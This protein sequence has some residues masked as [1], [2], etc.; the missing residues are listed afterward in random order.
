MTAY[1]IAPGPDP[2][3]QARTRAGL[4]AGFGAYGLWGLLPLY[5]VLLDPA[6]PTEIVA[7]RVLFSLVFCL[8]LLAVTR[9]LGPLGRALRAPRTLGA[10]TLAGALIGVNWFLYT[11]ATTTGNTL[12]ASL[13]YFINPLVAV[14]L[15]VVVLHERMRPLQWAAIAVGFTAVV[16]M[17]V[18]YGQVPWLALGLAFSFG[19]Y[20]LVKNLVGGSYPAIVTLTVETMALAPVA[21]WAVGALAADGRLTL[22]TEG[23]SHLLLL[24]ASGV[25]TAVPLILFGVAASR[26]P[27]STVGMIQYLAPIMQFLIAV[28]VLGELMPFVRWVGFG[29]VWLAVLLLVLDAARAPRAHRA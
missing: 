18:F 10:L 24:L 29:F 21:A 11:V 2:A 27:L 5:F 7:L 15:G 1:N 28:L 3:A 9:Q 12:E 25:I 19:F 6:S 23:P 8:L 16:V 17:A 13:G 20:G 26:L 22:G 14:L 4:L